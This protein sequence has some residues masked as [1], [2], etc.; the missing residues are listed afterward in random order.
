VAERAA[1]NTRVQRTRSS[2]SPPRSPLTRHPLGDGIIIGVVVTL[3]AVR[4]S[5]SVQSASAGSPP[6]AALAYQDASG[7]WHKDT[8]GVVLPVLQHHVS[9]VPPGLDRS[10]WVSGTVF[11]KILVTKTGAVDQV[12]ITKSLSHAMD[13]EAVKAVRQWSYSPATLKGDPVAVWMSVTVA[14]HFT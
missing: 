13:Q 1:P 8:S 12:V 3:G 9:P 5:G 10:D 6:S 11:L 2:A 7:T 4:C 14:W